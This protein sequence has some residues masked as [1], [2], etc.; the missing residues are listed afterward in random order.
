M[1]A[2]TARLRV[3]LSAAH[4]ERQ[5]DALIA[6]ASRSARRMSAPDP[7]KVF[8]LDRRAV[9][10]AFDRASASYDAAAALQERVRNELIEQARGTQVRAV[11]PSS[12][13]ARAQ[14]TRRAR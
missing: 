5:V 8:S 6:R 3:T 12:I 2:G 10:Q 7:T 13:S 9:V 4:E 14:A 1:P 11:E